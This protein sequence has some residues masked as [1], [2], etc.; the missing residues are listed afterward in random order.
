[1][2]FT[3]ENNEDWRKTMY[4]F[5]FPS[6]YCNTFLVHHQRSLDTKGGRFCGSD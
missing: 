2:Y 3:N 1:M 5:F 4:A 6:V